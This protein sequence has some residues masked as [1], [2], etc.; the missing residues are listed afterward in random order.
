MKNKR[1][2]G[3]RIGY[4]LLV[5]LPALMLIPRPGLAENRFRL[6]NLK[7]RGQI[8]EIITEDLNLDGLDDIVAVHFLEDEKPPQ[9]W[10]S[11]LWQDKEKGFST[12]RAFEFQPDD[13]VVMIDV[14]QVDGKDGLDLVFQCEDGVKYYPNQ[15]LTFGPLTQ[16]VDVQSVAALASPTMLPD[17]DFVRDLNRDGRDDIIVFQFTQALVYFPDE[18]GPGQPHPISLRPRLDIFSFGNLQSG[19]SNQQQTLRI[20]YFLPKVH[21]G[22]FDGDERVDLLVVRGR[23]VSVFLQQPDGTFSGEPA[24]SFR[25]NVFPIK[26]ESKY[27]NRSNPPNLAW[28]DLDQ[29]GKVD[30]VTHYTIGNFGKMKSKFQLYWGRTGSIGSGKPDMEVTTENTS[31]DVYIVDVNKDGLVD[32]VVPT[33]DIGVLLIGKI[34]FTGDVEVEWLYYLQKPDRSFSTE[35][36][37]TSSTNLQFDLEKLELEGGIPS[38][39]GDFNGDGYPD[40]ALGKT[41]NELVVTIKDSQGKATGVKESLYLPVS[42]MPLVKDFNHDGKSDL[43]LNYWDDADHIG[44]LRILTNIGP[45]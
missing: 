1:C 35:Q 14:G 30:L 19:V 11:V 20:A 13:K 26:E 7:L 25:V 17:Y 21:L 10:V 41:N 38:I 22:D 45:W 29:D 32:L 39:F 23:D 34:L 28:E 33:V 5:L 27:R 6:D 12:K 31:F 24:Q 36:D 15:G 42:M 40:Q 16:L 44:Q 43:I 8:K 9:R 4:A 3:K 18:Q 37:F 2:I